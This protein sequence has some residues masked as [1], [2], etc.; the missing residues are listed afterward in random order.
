MR[1]VEDATMEPDW[2]VCASGGGC[3][4]I[5]VGS[6][7]AYLEHLDEEQRTAFLEQL[8]PGA[9]IDLCGTRLSEDLMKRL[10]A[11]VTS[12]SGNPRF[13]HAR[14][15]GARFEGDA[16]FQEAQFTRGANYDKAHF[17]GEAWF[18]AARFGGQ[19]MFPGTR[20]H[21]PASFG[22][23]RFDAE[24]LFLGAQFSSNSTSRRSRWRDGTSF[25][26]H[27]AFFTEARFCGDAAF[28]RAQFSG[29]A[30]FDH[31]EFEAEAQFNGAQFGPLASF[32]QARFSGPE[33]IGPLCAAGEVVLD[34]AAFH[35]AI[36][37]EIAAAALTMVQTT[38]RAGATIRVRYAAIT[39]DRA[40]LAQPGILAAAPPLALQPSTP[41]G[42]FT[43]QSDEQPGASLSLDETALEACK[44]NPRPRAV[45]L[46]GVDVAN[47]VMIDLAFAARGG[48]RSNT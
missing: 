7:D 10:L 23:A 14:F 29:P 1:E 3:I 6:N 8:H 39:M 33:W 37:I 25:F 13:G 9:D 24:A 19:A 34:K 17:G 47:L 2:P 28:D 38:F 20:F 45:S 40:T 41:A 5:R 22:A 31:A 12:D 4:G 43:S 30:G 15:D 21:G 26:D 48:N 16:S 18:S 35:K 46:R 44:L 42:L 32:V 11:A 36:Q 27:G